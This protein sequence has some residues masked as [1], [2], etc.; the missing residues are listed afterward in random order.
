VTQAWG[1]PVNKPAAEPQPEPEPI[2][3][4]QVSTVQPQTMQQQSRPVKRE[5]P[6]ISQRQQ[7][8]NALFA[9]IGATKAPARKPGRKKPN[10]VKPKQA[11]AQVAHQ[12]AAAAP[13]MDIFG[14]LGMDA[15]PAQP[16]QA[17]PAAPSGD[18]DL[19]GMFGSPAP[20][21]ASTSAPASNMGEMDIFG[22]GGVSV[23]PPAS[24]DPFAMPETKS[25]IGSAGM[26]AAV[27]QKVASLTP[28]ESGEAQLISNGPINLSTITYMAPNSTNICLFVSNTSGGALQ[29]VRMQLQQPQGMQFQFDGDV[30]NRQNQNGQVGIS[31]ANLAAGATNTQIIMVQCTQVVACQTKQLQGQILFQGSQPQTFSVNIALVDL[32]RP[33]NIPTPAFGNLWKQLPGQGQVKFALR[34]S[35]SSPQEFMTR[36]SKQMHIHPVQTIKTENI[37]AGT[38][39]SAQ[40]QSNLLCLVHGKMSQEGILVLVRSA[41]P[42]FSQSLQAPLQTVLR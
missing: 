10:Q 42:Q 20:A 6:Q 23:P 15:A 41:H 18:L 21:Q 13:V 31:I 25:A 26:S 4:Q 7:Q 16:A 5:K 19:M 40:Q 24:L 33:L 3:P 37:C 12:A 34:S 8:A 35:C 39:V 1:M 9:G 29:N 17:Q 36:M 2:T 11:S 14:S 32:L 30:A 27:S 22:S 28:S 38:L